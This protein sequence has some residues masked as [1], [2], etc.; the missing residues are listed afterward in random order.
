MCDFLWRGEAWRYMLRFRWHA[1]SCLSSMIVALQVDW[2]RNPVRVVL[3]VIQASVLGPPPLGIWTSELSQ[4]QA[5][6]RN[7]DQGCQPSGPSGRLDRMTILQGCF[8]T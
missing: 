8:Q 2:N 3:V 5:S 1:F 6:S 7:F 4:L